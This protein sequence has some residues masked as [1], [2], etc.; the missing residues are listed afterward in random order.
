MPTTFLEDMKRQGARGGVTHF[1][2]RDI[3]KIRC[4]PFLRRVTRRPQTML[5][6]NN[7]QLQKEKMTIRKKNKI[8][9]AIFQSSGIYISAL[10]QGCP[11]TFSTGRKPCRF[12]QLTTVLSMV[13]VLPFDTQG[14]VLLPAQQTTYHFSENC[15]TM[16]FFFILR[17]F[18]LLR[19][20]L[21]T[22]TPRYISVIENVHTTRCISLHLRQPPSMNLNISHKTQCTP[23]RQYLY[24]RQDWSCFDTCLEVWKYE[25]QHTKSE[26]ERKRSVLPVKK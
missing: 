21:G 26:R 23:P 13:F 1:P 20:L 3:I 17:R 4:L 16:L 5:H 11:R 24:T 8:P 25:R 10:A 14:S 7:S 18:H 12:M 9:T 2:R 6:R 15:C 19:R 22:R